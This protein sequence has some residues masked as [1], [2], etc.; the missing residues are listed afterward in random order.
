MKK[1]ISF[2]LIMS[3]LFMIVLGVNVQASISGLTTLNISVKYGQTEA[4]TM[5]DMINKFRMGNDAWYWDEDNTQK[6]SCQR[7]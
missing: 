6:I 7:I 3:I 5:L 4:R 2:I 1:V